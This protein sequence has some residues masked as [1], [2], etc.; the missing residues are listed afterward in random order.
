MN[1]ATGDNTTEEQKSVVSTQN[2]TMVA[3]ASS[4]EEVKE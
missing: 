4:I 1:D 2:E 3:T